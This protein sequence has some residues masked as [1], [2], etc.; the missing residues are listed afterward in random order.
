MSESTVESSPSLWERRK[1]EAMGRIQRVALELFDEHGY[2]EVTV[3]RVAGA[4]GVSPS[5]IYRYF[6]TKENLVLYD[7]TDPKLLEIVRT[8][9]GGETR[10]PLD[11][12]AAARPLIPVLIDEIVTDEVEY[13][14]RLRMGYVRTIPEVKLG[15]TQQ[16]RE[17]EDQ[18]RILLA[19][20]TGRDRNDVQM[21]L[22]SAI[23]IW[24]SMAALDHW[25]G[26][27][28]AARLREV[29]REVVESIVVALEAMFR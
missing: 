6:G 2:R 15:Q 24:G 7:E 22:A 26:T 23:A 13:R 21:R 5:S 4:A 10:T 16:M 25:A 28:F 8:V 19:D 20:R 1:I 27:G 12:L 11:L 18:F 29:Y 9:G 14:T 3:E 17:L